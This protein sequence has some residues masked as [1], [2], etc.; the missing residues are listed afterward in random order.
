MEA[1]KLIRREERRNSSTGSMTNI[2]HLDGLI[3][4]AAKAPR[5]GRKGKP[6]LTVVPKGGA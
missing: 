5:A 1:A 3:K 4:A 2:Y 6:K